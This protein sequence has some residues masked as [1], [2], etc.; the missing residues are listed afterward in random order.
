MRIINLANAD[1]SYIEQAS[2]IL[3]A[4]FAATWPMTLDDA[5]ADVRESLEPSCVSRVALDEHGHVIGFIAAI[6]RYGDPPHA[7]GWELHPLAVAPERQGEGIG[8]ALVA[9]LERQVAALGAATLFAQTDDETGA[10][11]LSG[12]DLYDDPFAHLRAI[13]SLKP[14]PYEF[15]QKCGFTLVGVIPDANGI[16]KPDIVLAKR[17]R[18]DSHLS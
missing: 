4:A 5:L 7:T 6:P 8:R 9:D 10:T 13:R 18:Q 16:G 11:T 14:H 2:A 1:E 15:Y 3:V 17:I 12:V